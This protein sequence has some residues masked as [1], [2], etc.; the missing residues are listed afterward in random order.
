M[1]LMMGTND[2]NIGIN[3]EEI[4]C[5]IEQIIDMEK[6]NLQIQKYI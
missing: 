3:S 1:F 4:I 6:N 5:N 2:I